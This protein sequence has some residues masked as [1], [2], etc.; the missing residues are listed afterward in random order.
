MSI[1]SGC[2]KGSPPAKEIDGENLAILSKNF[3]RYSKESSFMFLKREV[4]TWHMGQLKLQRS[5][6]KQFIKRGNGVA[7]FSYKNLSKTV[8]L[9]VKGYF[10]ANFIFFLIFR[11]AIIYYFLI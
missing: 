10:K 2:I 11:L 1:I 9:A 5:V 6:M 4:A 7:L 8:C 3:F